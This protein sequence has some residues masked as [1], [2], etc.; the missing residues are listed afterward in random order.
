VDAFFLKTLEE[1]MRHRTNARLT[2]AQRE[3]IR[4]WF[5]SKCS[6]RQQNRPRSTF[7]HLRS[8]RLRGNERPTEFKEGDETLLHERRT[9]KFARSLTLPAELDG[10]KAEAAEKQIRQAFGEAK[11]KPLPAVV[12][13]D[14]FKQAGQRE[15]IEEAPIE[16][17]HFHFAWHIPDIRHPDIPALDVL[18]TLLGN[19]PDALLDVAL[20]VA[21]EGKIPDPAITEVA[22]VAAPALATADPERLSVATD[23]V[24]MSRGLDVGLPWMHD[25]GVLKAVLPEL[26]ATVDFSQEAGRRHKDVWEHTKQVVHQTVPHPL[27]RWAALLHDIGKVKT[28]VLL[29]DGKVT[30]HGHAEV[31]ARMFDPIAKRLAFGKPDRNKIRFLIMHHLRANAYEPAW[32]DAAVRRFDHEMG[33][34]LDDLL[35]L[36]R[37]D[38]TSRR[39]GRRQ[40]A[41]AAIQEAV[42]V[43]RELA[44]RWPDAYHHD[45]EQSLRVVAWLE[46]G[47]DLGDASR[48]S[49]SSDNGPSGIFT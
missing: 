39:P 46:H 19:G 44:A 48:G 15:I 2:D 42:T 43:H 49:R 22:R 30:F 23:A 7:A 11:T 29:P 37:A 45:L 41:V 34:H 25:A 18:A 9:G 13:P 12:L 36:S 40:E 35:D 16:L 28:R 4:V 33:E 5:E 31:G 32:T 1:G 20:R 24:I 3:V 8:D 21:A 14:E 27:T 17:G 6:T 26:E 38:V 10:A 47:E